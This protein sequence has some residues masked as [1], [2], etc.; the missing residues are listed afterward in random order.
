VRRASIEFALPILIPGGAVYLLANLS[1]GSP[2]ADVLAGKTADLLDG[3]AAF[4]GRI[5][6]STKGTLLIIVI[7]D[8]P[9]DACMIR[10]QFAQHVA[11]G[12]DT[13][14]LAFPN[15]ARLWGVCV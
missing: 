7:R 5:S 6:T 13:P 3:T 11:R 1:H 15:Q 4:A 14:V 12:E 9:A 2:L 8:A 10:Q